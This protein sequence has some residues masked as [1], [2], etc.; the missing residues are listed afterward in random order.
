MNSCLQFHKPKDYALFRPI[1]INVGCPLWYRGEPSI[2]SPW[3]WQDASLLDGCMPSRRFFPDGL[4]IYDIYIYDWTSRAQSPLLPFLVLSQL[5]TCRPPTP[6]KSSSQIWFLF[7]KF[8]QCSK[9]NKKKD[10]VI[11]SF[12]DILYGRFC[13]QNSYLD[14]NWQKKRPTKMFTQIFCHKRCSETSAKSIFRFSR[15]LVFEIWSILYSEY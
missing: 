7:Q 14:Y 9:T 15:F 8:A 1:D 12:R 3:C 4:Y 6:F 2:F 10:F 5:T 13:A 11:F